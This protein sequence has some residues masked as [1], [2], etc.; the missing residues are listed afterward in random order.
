MDIRS[1]RRAPRR[2]AVGLALACACMLLFSLLPLPAGMTRPGMQ[3]V[4]I[5][6]SAILLWTTEALPIC[7]TAIGLCALMPLFGI[8][9]YHDV[10]S[11]FGAGT[12]L[13]IMATSGITIA[14]TRTTIPLRITAAIIRATR[15]RARWIIFGFCLVSAALSGIMS[16]L[17][18]CAL[19]FGIVN[20]MLKTAGCA[21]GKSRL[22][23]AL[24]IAL[25]VSCGVG[26][27]LTPAG[28]PGNV[29]LMELAEGYGIHITFAQWSAVGIPTGLLTVLLAAL[30]LPVVFRP[31]DV[32]AVSQEHIFA[33]RARLGPWTGY[34]K[35][36][37]FVIAAM[38]ACWFAGSWI[39]FLNTTTVAV[40]GM[41][42]MFLPGVELM[43]WPTF[44]AECDWN[45]VFIMG[46]ASILVSGVS[47][48]GAMDWFVS[49]LFAGLDALPPW[50]MWLAVSLLVCVLRAF[51]PTTTA[52]IALFAPMLYSVSLIT[53]A[54]AAAL[55]MIPAFW[56]PAAMLML[57]TEP[58]FLITFGEGYYSEADLLR[59]G[60][61]PS[62]LMAAATAFAFPILMPLLGF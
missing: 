43:D 25:P 2:E 58:I 11:G 30:W 9:G 8:L 56:A 12:A 45:L 10:M 60:W 28:T 26:G 49:I 18:T 48:T 32:P 16:S 21:P 4:G 53:G 22:G 29:L 3:S 42:V 50:L 20:T 51:I 13:F 59:F 39:P 54:N 36:A 38:L 52:V 55:L 35:K 1:S 14:L 37:V 40:L 47:A 46:T 62:L 27:F 24:M 19:F 41:A 44:H 23:K 31:E 17:A 34:E 33:Q 7:V 61:L 57:Y 5:F 15:G 6:C